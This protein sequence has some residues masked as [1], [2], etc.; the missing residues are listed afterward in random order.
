M[1]VPFVCLLSVGDSWASC[2]NTL[3]EKSKRSVHASV[4]C[5]QICEKISLHSVETDC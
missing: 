2:F 4:R 5:V 1:V 3:K